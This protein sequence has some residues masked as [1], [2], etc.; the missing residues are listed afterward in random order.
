M[1]GAESWD[2]VA[3]LVLLKTLHTVTLTTLGASFP[4]L[5]STLL[6]PRSSNTF[7]QYLGP[8]C[9]FA[10]NTFLALVYLDNHH[11]TQFKCH[12]R[13][14]FPK[15]KVKKEKWDSRQAGHCGCLKETSSSQEEPNLSLRV[16][17]EKRNV[18]GLIPLLSSIYYN[19][20]GE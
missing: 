11:S 13:E 15:G 9:S 14:A 6:N 17:L 10:Q 8:S 4:A 18:S 7:R 16:R 2:Q 5:T 12:F 20:N 3:W 1:Q 19:L